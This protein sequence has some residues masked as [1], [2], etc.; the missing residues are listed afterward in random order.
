MVLLIKVAFMGMFAFDK[1]NSPRE[2]EHLE[3]QEQLKSAGWTFLGA[4]VPL[5]FGAL[6]DVMGVNTLSC[7]DWNIGIMMAF[8]LP[9]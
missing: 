2:Q 7:I 6:M 3:G 8:P 4:L 1:L 9:F 5:I